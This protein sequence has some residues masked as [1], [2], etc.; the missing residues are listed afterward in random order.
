MAVEEIPIQPDPANNSIGSLDSSNASSI[1]VIIQHAPPPPGILII[2][3]NY[4]VQSIFSSTTSL[5]PTNCA[6]A[7]FSNWPMEYAESSGSR[8][9]KIAS[10]NGSDSSDTT[11]LFLRNKTVNFKNDIV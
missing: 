2:T 5:R 4:F 9:A 3:N 10:R 8:L 11:G 6:A 1:V 7:T